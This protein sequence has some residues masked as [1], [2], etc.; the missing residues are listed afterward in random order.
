MPA[1]QPLN[2]MRHANACRMGVPHVLFV[3]SAKEN[4]TY[5][6]PEKHL[7]KAC[8]YCPVPTFNKRPALDSLR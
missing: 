3:F 6:E 7:P 5:Q 2:K 8:M 4:R 1:T